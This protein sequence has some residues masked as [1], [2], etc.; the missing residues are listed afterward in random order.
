MC[1]GI[2]REG[3]APEVFGIY[4][5]LA[6]SD[7]SSAELM[8]A[9]QQVLDHLGALEPTSS[10]RGLSCLSLSSTRNLR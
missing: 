4:Q 8:K 1:I 2:D 5:H 9:F 3:H 10:G 7:G 6:V